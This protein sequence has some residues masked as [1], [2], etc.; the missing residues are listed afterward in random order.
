MV[1][2]AVTL[3]ALPPSIILADV[4]SGG[5]PDVIQIISGFG[6]PTAFAILWI[7]GLI[8]SGRELDR[9]IADRNAEREER[10]RLQLIINERAI[11]GAGRQAA[12]LEQAYPLMEEGARLRKELPL[13]HH[14]MRLAEDKGGE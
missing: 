13:L 6:F 1:H 4:A 7:R 9:V 12:A 11:P 5:S 2:P 14:L 3:A 10:R 8:C